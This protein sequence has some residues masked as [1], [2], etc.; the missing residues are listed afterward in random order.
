MGTQTD[1]HTATKYDRSAEVQGPGNSVD[2]ELDQERMRNQ[3][4]HHRG[5]CSVTIGIQDQEKTNEDILGV[6]GNT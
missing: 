6:G 4:E 5:A 3:A 1:Q 2:Q